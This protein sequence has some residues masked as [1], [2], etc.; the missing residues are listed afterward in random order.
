MDAVSDD[1][2]KVAPPLDKIPGLLVKQFVGGDFGFGD[3]D[4]FPRHPRC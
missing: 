3:G 1:R 2:N 4:R